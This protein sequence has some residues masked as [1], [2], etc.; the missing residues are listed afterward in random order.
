MPRDI[1]ELLGIPLNICRLHG[2]Y[3]YCCTCVY[4]NSMLDLV[5]IR[6]ILKKNK[7][8][9]FNSYSLIEL[10]IFGSAVRGENSINSDL[11][12]LVE[13]LPDSKITLFDYIDLKTELSSILGYKIDLVQK[14]GL[15]PYIGKQILSEVEFI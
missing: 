11:D 8:K 6:H 9:L 12:I 4:N 1:K 14:S 2:G 7:D 15:K 10:G 3:Y 5:S 13:F